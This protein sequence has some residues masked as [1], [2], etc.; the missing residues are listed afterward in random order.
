MSEEK[1]G[2]VNVGIAGLGRSGWNIHANYIEQLA[3]KFKV[4]AVTDPDEA[5]RVAAIRAIERSDVSFLLIDATRGM[6]AQDVNIFRLIQKNKKGIVLVVNKW[7]LVEKDHQTIDHFREQ[8]A[9]KIKPFQ[10]LPVVFISAKEQQR[11]L[12]MLD[13]G[14]EVYKNR[15]KR[16]PTSRLNE[17]MLQAIEEF[18]PPSV[19]GKYVRIKYVTQLPVKTPAFAFF[20]NLPQYIREPYKRYLENRLR[21]NFNFHGVPIDIFFRKK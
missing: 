8:I 21:E 9:E 17:V 1:S 16:I 10:D 6:E 12:K 13:T 14:L 5:V 4:V 20:C 15:Q 2:I 11:V 3:D 7:D 19:K 18:P